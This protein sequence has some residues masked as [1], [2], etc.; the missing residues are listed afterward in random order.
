[1]EDVAVATG[2]D[3]DEVLL[4]TR[5]SADCQRRYKLITDVQHSEIVA[6]LDR[7]VGGAR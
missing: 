5:L 1:M 4:H 2:T 3:A 6:V 7:A